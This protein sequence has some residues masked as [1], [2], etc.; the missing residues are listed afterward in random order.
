MIRFGPDDVSMAMELGR[1]A[2]AYV[3]ATFIKVSHMF[4]IGFLLDAFSA[5]GVPLRGRLFTLCVLW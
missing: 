5:A 2:A 1:E 4:S 3:S